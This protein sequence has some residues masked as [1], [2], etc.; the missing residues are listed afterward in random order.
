[1]MVR[2]LIVNLISLC[3]GIYFYEFISDKN[4]TD[5]LNNSGYALLG[6]LF[7]YFNRA[8]KHQ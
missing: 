6:G 7:V 5:A 2:N 1:M 3:L 4:Y 8:G